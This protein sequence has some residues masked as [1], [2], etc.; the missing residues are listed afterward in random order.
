MGV[1]NITPDS[2]SDGGRF[3]RVDHAV[4]EAAQQLQQGADVLDLGG[5]STRPGAQ[6]VGAEEELRRVLPVIQET[7]RRFPT[8][9]LSVDTFL[10]P[11]AEAALKAGVN[12]VNDVSGGRR[13]PNPVSYTH[14]RAH[15]T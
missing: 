8:A 1:I 7:R 6:E 4:A 13:D 14:L 10:A 15:E 12:W 3:L 2:F 5:Q 9:L 11:V